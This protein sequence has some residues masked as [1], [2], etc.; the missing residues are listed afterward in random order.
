MDTE[1]VDQNPY[2]VGQRV[3]HRDF[4]AGVVEG[5]RG[6]GDAREIEIKFDARPRVLGLLLCFSGPRI[7]TEA[8]VG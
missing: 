8:H 5:Y 4:G 6:E 3:H 7:A 1:T 2:S